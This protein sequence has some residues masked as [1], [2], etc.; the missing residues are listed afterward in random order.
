MSVRD[1]SVFVLVQREAL[2]FDGVDLRGGGDGGI[3]CLSP[4]E[5]RGGEV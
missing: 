1:T 2:L 4:K 3:C 5:K